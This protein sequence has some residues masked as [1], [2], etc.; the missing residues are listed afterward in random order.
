MFA[1]AKQGQG[2]GQALADAQKVG[3]HHPLD[4]GRVEMTR[5]QVLAR[6]RIEDHQIQRSPGSLDLRCDPSD[7]DRVIDVAD[8]QQNLPGKLLHQRGKPLLV[9]TA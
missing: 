6:A 2:S 5:F 1:S 7:L 8:S 4:H 9:T 3:A